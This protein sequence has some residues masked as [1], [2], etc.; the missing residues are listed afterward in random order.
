MRVVDIG[1]NL[2]ITIAVLRG[3]LWAVWVAEEKSG[4]RKKNEGTGSCEIINFKPTQARMPVPQNCTNSV[5]YVAQSF[6]PVLFL[7]Q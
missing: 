4:D 6:L 1:R 2:E 3:A 5:G 7:W